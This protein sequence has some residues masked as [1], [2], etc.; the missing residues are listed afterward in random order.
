VWPTRSQ[1]PPILRRLQAAYF[2]AVRGIKPHPYLEMT[3]IVPPGS[4]TEA[5]TVLR[6]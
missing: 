6:A 1:R 2:D 5:R 4:E 3:M